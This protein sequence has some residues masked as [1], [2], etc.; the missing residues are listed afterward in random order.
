MRS[1]LDSAPDVSPEASVGLGISIG[2]WQ[3][4]QAMTGC[5]VLLCPPGGC[6]ASAAIRGAAPG[7]RETALLDPE[8]SN[9][10]IHALL[11][12]GGSAFGLEAA[13]GV[14]RFLAEQK[15]GFQTP[16]ACIPIVPAAVI[17]DLSVGDSQRYPDAD[18]G[19]QAAKQALSSALP[20]AQSPVG[21]VGVGIAA[22]CGKHAGAAYAQWGGLG[23]AQ[24]DVQGAQLVALT[25]ANPFG[26]IIDP[27][28][29][30]IIAGHAFA[31]GAKPD[32][33]SL[34]HF[35]A[36]QHSNT[37]LVAVL[38]DAQISKSEARVLAESAHV[39]IA[40]V[41]RPSHTPFDG[42]SSFA[43]SSNRGP[44]V[45]LLQLSVAVQ[46]LV[47]EAIVQGARAANAEESLV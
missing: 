5:T 46:E 10:A 39:G 19:Y 38:T 24:M 12:A 15:L 43:L 36:E 28:T 7:T 6:L 3:D 42:D 47:A 17:Y 25:V 22:T 20:V 23:C 29:G 9:A 2:H 32:I 44:Q 35:F 11:F 16:H 41:T 13:Q 26:N 8:K 4:T 14:V 40:R 1:S 21:R 45:D 34:R 18:A 30:S 27:D 37:T 31:R 33:A